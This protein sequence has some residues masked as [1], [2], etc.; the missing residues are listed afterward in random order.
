MYVKLLGPVRVTTETSPSCATMTH[1]DAAHLATLP[2]PGRRQQTI[3]ALLAV[4]LGHTVSVERMI[5]SLW[6]DAQPPRTCREQVQNCAA[7]VRRTLDSATSAD[8]TGGGSVP[9]RP[10]IVAWGSSYR[11]HATRA[12]VDAL[13]FEDAIRAEMTAAVGGS[14]AARAAR[15]RRCLTLWSGEPF[16]DLIAPTLAAEAARLEELRLLAIEEMIACELRAGVDPGLHVADLR[17]LTIRYPHRER[18]HLLQMEALHRCERTSEAILG[19]R[20]Y[21]DSLVQEYGI[22]PGPDIQVK[23]REILRRSGG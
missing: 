21:R 10:R 11:L 13:R 2:V 19:Y 8:P 5:D 7:A 16:A 1:G 15:L 20:T 6:P 4:N 17:A 22:E 9:T 14:A 12:E 23:A 3:L 18:L